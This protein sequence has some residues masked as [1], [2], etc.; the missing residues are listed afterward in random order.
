MLIN[1]GNLALQDEGFEP[2]PLVNPDEDDIQVIIQVYSKR[3]DKNIA[4]N[5]SH[6][7]LRSCQL[8]RLD[9]GS[10]INFLIDC[11]RDSNGQEA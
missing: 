8:G 10:I 7:E 9:F 4:Y 3:L 2:E 5:F 11:L 6:H 1:G